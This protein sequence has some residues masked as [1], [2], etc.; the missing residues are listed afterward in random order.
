MAVSVFSQGIL[1]VRYYMNQKMIATRLCENRNRPMLHC[2]GKCVL[3]KKL[4]QQEKQQQQKGI[5]FGEK[6]EV[7]AGGEN[8]DL[9]LQ[10]PIG[11]SLQYHVPLYIGVPAQQERVIFHPP[12]LQA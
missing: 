7:L 3:A 9:F 4:Q 1:V 10:H 8:T 11:I 5:F 12:D 6:F 2:E